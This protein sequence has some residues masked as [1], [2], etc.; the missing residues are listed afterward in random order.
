MLFITLIAGKLLTWHYGIATVSIGISTKYIVG[1]KGRY[2]MTKALDATAE[3]PALPPEVQRAR[4]GKEPML[5]FDVDEKHSHGES[6]RMRTAGGVFLRN[7]ASNLGREPYSI[8]KSNNEV[9]NEVQG[10]KLYYWAK[11]VT[12]PPEDLKLKDTKRK[13]VY[14]VDVDYYVDMEDLMCQNF[15]PIG[16]YTLQP[17]TASVTGSDFTM[18]WSEENNVCYIVSGGGTYE[19]K[20]WDWSPDCLIVRRNLLWVIPWQTAVY[21]VDR[22]PVDESHTIVSLTPVKRWTGLMAWVARMLEGKT[23]KR[24]C[25]V[26]HGFVR[27]RSQKKS[28]MFVS[29]ARAGG[30]NNISIPVDIDEA[31][32]V[33]ARLGSGKFTLGQ[34]A[35]WLD[36][37]DLT[38]RRRQA[39][40]AWDYHSSNVQHPGAVAF[41]VEDAVRSYDYGVMTYDPDDQKSMVAFMSP[42]YHGCY[43][44]VINVANEEQAIKGRITNIQHKKKFK[45]TPFV[46]GCIQEFIE[47]LVPNMLDLVPVDLQEVIA[48]QSKPSQQKIVE[49]AS[50]EKDGSILRAF[51][52]REAY[53]KVKDPRLI[54]QDEPTHKIEYASFIYAL[55][56]F[57]K[58]NRSGGFN[59][60]MPGLKPR[61]VAQKI[62]KIA[63][64]SETMTMADMVR[65][66]GSAAS[67]GREMF[68]RLCLRMLHP[69]YHAQ[70]IELDNMSYMRKVK[71]KVGKLKYDLKWSIG[72]GMM[73]TSFYG[74][75]YTVFSV[76]VGLRMTREDRLFIGPNEA[77]WYLQ[78]KV[79][80][81]GDDCNAG[82]VPARSLIKG[83]AAVG[84]VSEAKQIS[85]GSEGVEF[86]SRR[87]GPEIW[88]GD[89]ESVSCLK[90]LLSKF[91]TTVHLGGVT[92]IEKLQEKARSVLLTDRNT[93]VI[94]PFCA[95]VEEL[96]GG[97]LLRRKK[98]AKLE[99]WQSDVGRKDQYPNDEKDWMI[100]YFKSELP[101]FDLDEFN[102]WLIKQKRLEDMLQVPLFA[103]IE[104]VKVKEEVIVSGDILGP[105]NKNAKEAKETPQENPPKKLQKSKTWRSSKGVKRH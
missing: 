35:A 31:M 7:L 6:A 23:L 71:T 87:Y 19:H 55:V 85:A 68:Q 54:T 28:G 89:L 56:D 81:M 40:V 45:A 82:D 25:P 33:Q 98:T 101:N 80:A 65:L 79:A 38:E 57:V 59:F 42:L 1:K 69:N 18:T 29:T 53:Q 78:N 8:Q 22:R 75:M 60:F 67:I 104:D 11:D 100:D 48:R 97:K 94:G 70:F 50:N 5:A 73:N 27:I 86:L 9:K 52:K 37:E 62:G 105:E 49:R 20:V 43:A 92:P 66:D 72:S 88:E 83:A 32:A 47:L 41:P 99:R 2:I 26:Q 63:E 15:V 44:P 64:G 17:N 30:V 3:R 74:T 39:A 61:E 12:S 90:R 103:E 93:P 14:M 91:H 24:F 46:L 36:E 96:S 13:F 16:L 102:N 21:L 58:K 84:L 76:Y 95:K 51:L 77:F 34:A 4:F 10:S